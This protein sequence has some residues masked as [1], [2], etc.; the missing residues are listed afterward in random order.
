MNG[1]TDTIAN[2]VDMPRGEDTR[3]HEARIVDMNAWKRRNH[4]SVQTGGSGNKPP[5]APKTRTGGG[6]D[7]Y[8]WRSAK[9]FDATPYGGIR[10]PE[11]AKNY[12][13]DRDYIDRNPA[14]K[15]F[16]EKMYDGAESAYNK[17]ILKKDNNGY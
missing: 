5:K 1:S 12:P 6:G 15:T 7:F 4:P 8:D 16:I 9:D 11:A 14:N 10:R 13:E 2:L 17:Y 3:N